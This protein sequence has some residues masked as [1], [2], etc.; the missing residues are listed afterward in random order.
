[1]N[2]LKSMFAPAYMMSIAIVTAYA[3]FALAHS[4]HPAAWIGVLLTTAP[5]L[6]VLSWIMAFKT[7]ART[8]PHFPT[9]TAIG[10]AGTALAVWSWSVQDGDQLAAGLAAGE[11]LGFLI[12]SYWYS[13]LGWTPSVRIKVG[14]V[15][16]HFTLKN[17]SGASV[18]SAD[19]TD[20]PA[21]LIF[22]RGN[23]CPL[24]MA[25]IKELA[26]RYRDLDALGVRVALIL[27]QPHG[28]TVAL[29]RK[30]GVNSDFLTDN[31]NVAARALGIA[32]PWGLPMGMQMFGYASET[33]LPTVI[34]TSQ[35]GRVVWV[36]ETD[37][38]RIRPEPDTY[39]KVLRQQGVVAGAA[40]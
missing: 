4:T 21:V 29:A 11:W 34:I 40:A 27:P 14:S 35:G 5:F 19:L 6:M 24:C 20:R 25:Q 39:I 17:A 31:G 12:Y 30:Y 9:L 13:A 7:V 8:S 23:W 2:F 28:N 36:H 15:L 10:A 3:G 22:Y 33:V 32:M 26:K 18:N 37:N 38:Y 1:M 16:P